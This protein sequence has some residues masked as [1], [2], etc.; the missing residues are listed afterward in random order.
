[1]TQSLNSEGGNVL[2]RCEQNLAYLVS[3][4]PMQGYSANNARRGP[5]IGASV[6]FE[7]GDRKIT[8]IVNCRA[9]RPTATVHTDGRPHHDD[10]GGWDH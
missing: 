5:A 3:W 10:D 9:G 2:A 1:V 7:S 6:E 4:T 8:M